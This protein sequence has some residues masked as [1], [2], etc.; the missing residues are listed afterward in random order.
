ME[1]HEVFDAATGTVGLQLARTQQPDLAIVD[2]GLP[3][4]SGYD[5]AQHLRTAPATHAVGL[6]ALTGYG[7]EEDRHSALAAGF[8]F[9]LVKPVDI[10]R[11]LE[12]IDQCGQTA[13]RRSQKAAQS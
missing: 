3:E 2:I 5:I 8:D 1:G 4:M 10:N 13:R 7:Q 12:V 9:H 11:L 6:I